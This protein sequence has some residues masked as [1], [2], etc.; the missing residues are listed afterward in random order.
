MSGRGLGHRLASGARQ[1][2]LPHLGKRDGLHYALGYNGSGVAMAPYLGHKIAL[3]LL[4][5]FEG[6]S[7]FDQAPFR[8]YPFYTGRPWFLP[9]VERWYQRKDRKEGTG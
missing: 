6:L 9:L 4:G 5:R 2:H 1:D 7:P 8:A 3:Q